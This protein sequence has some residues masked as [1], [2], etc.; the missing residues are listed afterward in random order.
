MSDTE[1]VSRVLWRRIHQEQT[2]TAKAERN[3]ASEKLERSLIFERMSEV[4]CQH[5]PI[6]KVLADIRDDRERI[7]AIVRYVVIGRMEL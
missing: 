1:M 3:C 2:K 6:A 7:I 4:E 5:E